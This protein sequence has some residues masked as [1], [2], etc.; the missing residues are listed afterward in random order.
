MALRFSVLKFILPILKQYVCRNQP[1]ND[2]H[3]DVQS[4]DKENNCPNDVKKRILKL[5]ILI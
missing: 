2:V 3:C 4:E 1:G 5:E